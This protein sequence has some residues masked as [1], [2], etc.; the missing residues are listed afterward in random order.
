MSEKKYQASAAAP[1]MLIDAAFAKNNETAVYWLTAS[2]I[3]VNSHGTTIMMDPIISYASYDPLMSETMDDDGI[4]FFPQ[5]APVPIEAKDVKKLDAVLITHTDFDHLG[6]KTVVD[7]LPSG[8]I[9]YATQYTADELLR[10]RIPPQ[11]IK[12]IKAH[13]RFTLGEVEIEVTPADHPW[14]DNAPNLDYT[15]KPEDCCGFK[16]YCQEGIIWNTGDTM[17]LPEHMQHTDAD[18]VFMDFSD[19]P[20]SCHFGVENAIMLANHMAKA[21]IVIYHWG[22]HDAA[23]IGWCNCDPEE[24]RPQINNPG[25][26]KVLTPGEKYLLYK[27]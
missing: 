20:P 26:F 2:G 21:D 10:L 13:D 1:I 15:F 24:I 16:L 6:F 5:L 18:L 23:D 3:F 9:Y 19:D 22:T 27:K 14:Q 12:V 11:R 17:L 7:L 8:A 25:R 4:D